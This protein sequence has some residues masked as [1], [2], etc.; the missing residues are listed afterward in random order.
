MACSLYAGC[1]VSGATGNPL[2]VLALSSHSIWRPAA[3]ANSFNR[4]LVVIG[5]ASSVVFHTMPVGAQ[6]E[7]KRRAEACKSFE[8][9][10]KLTLQE[11]VELHDEEG[12]IE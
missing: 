11:L 10:C 2:G 4:S 12:D 7:I 3:P 8:T 6:D 9:I 5:R 1:G